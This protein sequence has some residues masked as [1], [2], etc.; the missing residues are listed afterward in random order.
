[1]EHMERIV[2]DMVRLRSELHGSA[3]ALTTSEDELR[4]TRL[5]IG[6]ALDE[7]A[8]DESKLS[9]SLE[10]DAADL[11]EATAKANGA[12]TSLLARPPIGHVALTRGQPL[13]DED[14]VLLQGLAMIIETVRETQ[15][16]L[17]KLQRKQAKNRATLDDVRFQMEQLKGRLTTLN[18]ASSAS[19]SQVQERVQTT[20]T[21]LRG[22][23]DQ[24]V[25]EAER[26]S[27]YLRTQESSTKLHSEA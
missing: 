9:R 8:S 27:F 1:M 4:A 15:A 19:Q 3:Q 20:E 23:M 16:R 26:V 21:K 18:A 11:G 13:S 22:E 5:R 24:L 12:V 7:L 6:R 2:A 14:A 25:Q 17:G 10:A